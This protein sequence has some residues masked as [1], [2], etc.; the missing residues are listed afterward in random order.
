MSTGDHG[1]FAG[2]PASQADEFAKRD[3]HENPGNFGIRVDLRDPGRIA[4][5]LGGVPFGK[6]RKR[7]DGV[8]FEIDDLD[9][10]DP[11]VRG[12]M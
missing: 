8:G 10:M 4:V 5:E 6:F 2:E 12:E 3:T 1:A 7:G 11:L 9:K